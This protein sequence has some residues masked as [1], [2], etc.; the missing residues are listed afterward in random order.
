MKNDELAQT[1][2]SYHKIENVGKKKRSYKNQLHSSCPW[3]GG[4]SFQSRNYSSA[5]EIYKNYSSEI[6]IYMI[7]QSVDKSNLAL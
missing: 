6:E 1:C 5:I 4:S 7:V 2:V 3:L